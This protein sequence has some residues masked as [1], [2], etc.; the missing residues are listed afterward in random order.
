[1]SETCSMV[2]QAVQSTARDILTRL[3]GFVNGWFEGAENNDFGVEFNRITK[4]FAGK[5]G[6]EVE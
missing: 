5:Y 3:L 6:V 2:Q 4:D 1:M